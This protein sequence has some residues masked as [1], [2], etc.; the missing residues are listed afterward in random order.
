[1]AASLKRSSPR[2]A[3]RSVMRAMATAPSDGSGSSYRAHVRAGIR[4]FLETLAA[5]PESAQTVLVEIIGAGPR[6]AERRD[7]ILDL[8]ADG[9]LRD[10]ARMAAAGH[11]LWIRGMRH[12]C[13]E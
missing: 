2:V 4:G 12:H 1:M 8:F 5:Y 6:A 9:L 7:A 11:G 3:P 13:E 10:N